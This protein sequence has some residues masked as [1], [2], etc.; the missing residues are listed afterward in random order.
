[1]RGKHV[2][3]YHSFLFIIPVYRG[4]GNFCQLD[5]VDGRHLEKRFYI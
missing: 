3:E 1:M 5:R 2:I 4:S